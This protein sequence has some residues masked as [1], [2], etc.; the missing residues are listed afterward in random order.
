VKRIGKLLV[1]ALLAA[2]ASGASG[3]LQAAVAAHVPA[4]SSEAPCLVAP[5]A[6][7]GAGVGEWFKRNR[8]TI[9]DS[10]ACMATGVGLGLAIAGM[11]G[12]VGAVAAAAAALR[13][14]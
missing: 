1:A 2:L 11:L 6:A 10:G 4:A 14:F 5:E 13:C 3:A 8:N 7:L 12:P 9:I